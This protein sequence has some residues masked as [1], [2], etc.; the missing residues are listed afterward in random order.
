[1]EKEFYLM[2]PNIKKDDIASKWSETLS[3]LDGVFNS[4]HQN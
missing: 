1:M 4:E 3:R 2:K